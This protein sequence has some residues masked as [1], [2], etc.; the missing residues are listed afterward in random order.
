MR[1]IL[2][3]STIVLVMLTLLGQCFFFQR[4]Q[5]G[6]CAASIL[7]TMIALLLVRRSRR[8]R[9]RECVPVSS[10]AGK[11]VLEA[12]SDT[13]AYPK[14]V[15]LAYFFVQQIFLRKSRTSICYRDFQML[16]T[17][18]YRD[19]NGTVLRGII[20]CIIYHIHNRSF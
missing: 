13:E 2:K 5:A 14:P 18:Y 9:G 12:M 6:L 19:M 17:A 1:K 4:G 7:I 8:A 10:V 3:K 11:K 16:L 15:N 20:H